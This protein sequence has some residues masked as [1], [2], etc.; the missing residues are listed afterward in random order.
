MAETALRYDA[1][2]NKVFKSAPRGKAVEKA[3]KCK[4]KGKANYHVLSDG[5]SLQGVS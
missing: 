3:I 5:H 2:Y 4:D 1:E